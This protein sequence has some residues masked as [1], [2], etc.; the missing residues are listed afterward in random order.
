MKRLPHP[1]GRLTSLGAG[2]QHSRSTKIAP[3]RRA[4]HDIAG[5]RTAA[6]GTTH[7]E[8]GRRP[9]RQTKEGQQP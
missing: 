1:F 4:Y 5:P 8:A 2:Q 7:H 6:G 3:G 9:V